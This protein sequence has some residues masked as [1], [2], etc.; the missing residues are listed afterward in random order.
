VD[1]STQTVNLTCSGAPADTTCTLS[2]S[3]ITLDG[4]DAVSSTVTVTAGSLV[5]PSSRQ[6]RF[7][8]DFMGRGPLVVA[9]LSLLA[10][11]ALMRRRRGFRLGFAAAALACLLFAGCGGGGGPPAGKF[12][13]VITGTPTDGGM[14]HTLDI[15]LTIE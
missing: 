6:R 3:S 9:G 1:N 4:V 12:T 5:P 13:L 15:A 8:G 10:I 2:P 11:F 14:V 7:P